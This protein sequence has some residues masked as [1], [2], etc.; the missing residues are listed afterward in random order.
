MTFKIL[1]IVS[2][3]PAAMMAKRP[4]TTCV[5]GV[6]AAFSDAAASDTAT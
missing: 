3:S 6:A 4:W 5:A 2:A 1:G